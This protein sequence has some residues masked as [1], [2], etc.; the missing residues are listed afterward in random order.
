M[1][2]LCCN[3]LSAYRPLRTDHESKF[4]MF[5]AWAAYP[6]ETSPGDD[7]QLDPSSFIIQLVRQVNFGSVEAKRYFVPDGDGGFVEVREQDIINA[8]FRK[9]NSYKNFKCAAHNKF[10]EFNLYQRDPVNMHH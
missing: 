1:A 3:G 9:V 2:L 8:N 5:K 7:V 10:Y 6:R 4:D